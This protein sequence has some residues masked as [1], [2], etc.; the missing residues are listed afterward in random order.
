MADISMC[1]NAK[2]PSLKKCYRA[3]AEPKSGGWDQSYMAF[4]PEGDK[5][6]DFIPLRE[7]PSERTDNQ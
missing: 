6:A 1:N 3:Q 5:C 7:V 2:C 4:K